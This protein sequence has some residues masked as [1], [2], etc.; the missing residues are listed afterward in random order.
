MNII[1]EI[2]RERASLITEEQ[3]QKMLVNLKFQLKYKDS[4]LIWGAPH[5]QNEY[6]NLPG[7]EWRDLR[8]PYKFH[9]AVSE[10]LQS[11]GFHTRRW[12]NKGGVE[13]GMEVWI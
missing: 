9:A 11:I 2:K 13:Q 10:W 6:W 3:K 7:E 4:A 12:F 5:F 8:V 1:D